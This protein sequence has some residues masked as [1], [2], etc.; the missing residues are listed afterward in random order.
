MYSHGLSDSSNSD[1]IIW[2]ND[3]QHQPVACSEYHVYC[4]DRVR[5][6]Q[7]QKILKLCT[8]TADTNIYITDEQTIYVS[9]AA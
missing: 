5:A 3:I 6:V 8:D 4:K 7:S 9:Q 1:P 2:F